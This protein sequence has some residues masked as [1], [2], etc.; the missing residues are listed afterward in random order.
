MNGVN[1][2]ARPRRWDEVHG[3]NLLR[4]FFSLHWET[5]IGVAMYWY[6]NVLNKGVVGTY[7][8]L[9]LNNDATIARVLYI[10]K[11]RTA[12]ERKLYGS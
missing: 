1:Q 6:K 5:S 11:S 10:H 12:A 8:I 2:E 9:K 7:S 4:H 3:C